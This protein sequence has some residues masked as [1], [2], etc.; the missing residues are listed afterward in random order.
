MN[1][2]KFDADHVFFKPGDA[3]ERAFQ[4]KS[5]EVEII[6]LDGQRLAR[7]YIGDVFGEMAL[8]EER[9]HAFM[10]R[11]VSDGV[12]ETL[13]RTEFEE[14][15]LRDP[16][17]AK[18]YLTRLF[19]RLRLLAARVGDESEPEDPAES[20]A[21]G[22][23]LAPLTPKA[24]ASLRDDGVALWKLPFRIGRASEA[25]EPEALDLNDLWLNDEKPFLVSRNH[26]SIDAF[27]RGLFVVRD[28]GSFLGTIV[29][30]E[31]IGGKS[32]RRAAEL[33]VGDNTIIIGPAESPFQF[34]LTVP[35]QKVV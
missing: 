7:L 31:T 15:L 29:N 9:P 3:S 17:R 28:R 2:L 33:K 24:R 21:T 25:N 23:M 12:A 26:L 19:E 32:K 11:A 1:E 5:G 14:S 4:I 13:T 35:A 16:T 30:G 18:H 34:R 22:L 20:H 10:A 8:V 27:D 6:N